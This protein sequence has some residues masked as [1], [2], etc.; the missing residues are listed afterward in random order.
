MSNFNRGARNLE[1]HSLSN[2]LL[3]LKDALS[4][5]PTVEI[6]DENKKSITMAK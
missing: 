2:T 5:W 1:E 6:N 3:P 4:T